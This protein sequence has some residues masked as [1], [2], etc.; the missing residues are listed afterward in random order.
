MRHIAPGR[1]TVVFGAGGDRD[2]GKRPDMGRVAVEGADRVVVTSDNPRTEDPDAIIDDIMAGIDPGAADRVERITDRVDAI[3]R[4]LERAE[5]GD[6]VLLAGKGHETYQVLGT[7]TVPLDE[8]VV[9]REWLDRE[10]VG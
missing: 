1:V 4:A 10:G 8:R 6:I 3:G 5:P 7:E 9:V 2:P